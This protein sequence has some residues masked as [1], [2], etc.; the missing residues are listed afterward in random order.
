MTD[1]HARRRG[2]PRVAAACAPKAVRTRTDDNYSTAR[3][4]GHMSGARVR[5]AHG[6]TPARTRDQMGATAP[7]AEGSCTLRAGGA[8]AIDR[9]TV[10]VA[11]RRRESRVAASAHPRHTNARWL[12]K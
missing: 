9:M 10:Q 1:I 8:R 4:G 7:R 12:T 11:R 3:E 6:G 5:R 2:A